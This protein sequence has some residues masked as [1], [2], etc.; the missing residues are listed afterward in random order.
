MHLSI[1]GKAGGVV[2][3]RGR[4]KKKG[5]KVEIKPLRYRRRQVGSSVREGGPWE[6][7]Y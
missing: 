2:V 3:V 7:P 5:S 6:L 1:L 4:R